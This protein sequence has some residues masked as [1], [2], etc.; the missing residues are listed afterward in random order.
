VELT[1][2]TCGLCVARFWT[3][4]PVNRAAAYSLLVLIRWRSAGR[5]QAATQYLVFLRHRQ[6]ALRSAL[7]PCRTA[8]IAPTGRDLRNAVC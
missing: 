6:Q 1:G 2:G 3:G 4:P 8:A 7:S 5:R